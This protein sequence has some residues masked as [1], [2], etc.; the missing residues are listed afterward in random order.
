MNSIINF[1]NNNAGVIAALGILIEVI[2]SFSVAI[3]NSKNQQKQR[4][5]EKNE[6][7]FQNKGEFEIISPLNNTEEV[8]KE[9]SIKLFFCSFNTIYKSKSEYEFKY[10]INALNRKLYEYKDF[11]I[12]NVGNANILHFYICA[13]NQKCT[14]LI[15]FDNRKFFL[16]N[17]CINY[18]CCF[19]RKISVGDKIKVR[20]YHLKGWEISELISCALLLVY[21]D[22]FHNLYEQPFFY[23]SGNLY[24]PKKIDYKTYKINI[25]ADKAYECFENPYLW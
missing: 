10:P 6:I 24:E 20:I 7:E 3:Y 9:N 23:N 19:D 22:S 4:K 17:K 14:S 16:N 25:T 12:K 21:E 11:Y 13:A 8:N 18:S 15:E 2:K 5:E 1:I